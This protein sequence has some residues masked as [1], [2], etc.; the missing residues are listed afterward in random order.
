MK[1]I[2]FFCH[3]NMSGLVAVSKKSVSIHIHV[4]FP[5]YP[6]IF[7]KFAYNNMYSIHV[8]IEYTNHV[9]EC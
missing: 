3:V 7:N 6:K 1:G 4:M 8:C 5:Q 9:H 2:L